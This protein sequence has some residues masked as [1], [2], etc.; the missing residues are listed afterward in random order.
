MEA[1]C[2]DAGIEIFLGVFTLHLQ[3][4]IKLSISIKK[5]GISKQKV[6][7]VFSKEY[8]FQL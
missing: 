8:R 4:F 1:Y 5:C 3:Y 6:S 7:S 2:V